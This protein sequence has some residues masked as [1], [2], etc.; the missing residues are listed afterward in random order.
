MRGIVGS[1]VTSWL[2]PYPHYLAATFPL[3]E[4]MHCCA[5]DDHVD[6]DGNS[7]PL[8]TPYEAETLFAFVLPTRASLHSR[9][10]FELVLDF[11]IGLLHHSLAASWKRAFHWMRA[12]P[13][14]CTFA[15]I[16]AF[17]WTRASCWTRAFPWTWTAP[18]MAD[19][20]HDHSPAERMI[21]SEREV[22]R[23]CQEAPH[24]P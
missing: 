15:Q 17:Q 4:V 5:V 14:M 2:L 7:A 21:D 6:H 24:D 3:M 12:F 16:L 23:P 1:G 10:G 19:D 11:A 18:E 22:C 13:A 9:Q 8:E 20:A